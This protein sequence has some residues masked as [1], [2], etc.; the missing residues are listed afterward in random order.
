[1][2]TFKIPFEPTKTNPGKLLHRKHYQMAIGLDIDCLA[3]R[4]YW[5]DVNGKAIRSSSYNESKTTDFI[6]NGKCRNSRIGLLL[7]G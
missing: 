1:M 7:Q 3:G 6:T 2:A 5:S 4:V